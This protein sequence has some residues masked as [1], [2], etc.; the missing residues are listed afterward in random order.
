MKK[1][2]SIIKAIFVMLSAIILCFITFLI[3]GWL[4]KKIYVPQDYIMFKFKTQYE[5]L[6]YIFELEYIVFIVGNTKNV[7]S[8]NDTKAYKQI[9]MFFRKHIGLSIAI[10]LVIL[11]MCVTGITVITKD[12]I[13]NYSFYNPLGTTYKYTQV[14][15]VETGFKSGKLG[16]LSGSKGEFYYKI[17]LPNSKGIDLYQSQSEYK[18]TYY[19]LEVFDYVLMKNKVKKVS[20]LNN[21]KECKLG[22]VYVDRFIKIIQNK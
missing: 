16:K 11:Y 7:F 14:K 4:Q 22:Q 12:S 8:N 3:I 6:V 21:L 17:Y 9:A 19:E 13:K 2:L 10:N 1:I 5:Y 15:K 18:E 20:S